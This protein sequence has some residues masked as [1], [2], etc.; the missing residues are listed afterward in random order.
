MSRTLA[1]AAESRLRR[2][3]GE[4]DERIVGQRAG[5]RHPLALAAGQLAGTL[6]MVALQAEAVQQLRGAGIDRVGAEPSQLADREG[7]V[8]ERAEFRQQ[9]VELEDIAKP[10]QAEVRQPVVVEAAGVL[11]VDPDTSGGGQVQQA[12]Q[13]EQR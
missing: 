13:V 1:L 9:E 2:F 10:R 4:D 8:V 7:D 5:D 12:E 3:V 6:V 11:A